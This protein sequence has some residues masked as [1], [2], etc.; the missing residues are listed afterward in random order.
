[1]RASDDVAG[2]VLADDWTGE[3]HRLTA[4][5]FKADVFAP[6][7]RNQ[8]VIESIA[9]KLR[10]E[11]DWLILHFRSIG[12]PQ[13]QQ[14][15]LMLKPRSLM[16]QTHIPIGDLSQRQKV[17][18]LCVMKWNSGIALFAR[19]SMRFSFASFWR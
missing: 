2:S 3:E 1:M 8:R 4:G 18:T 14:R 5:T 16:S 19:S 7:R 15:Q 17:E 11:S 10:D 6:V 9:G 12:P 13:Y